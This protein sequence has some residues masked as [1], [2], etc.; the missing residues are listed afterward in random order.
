M[1]FNRELSAVSLPTRERAAAK[2]KLRASKHSQPAAH[3]QPAAPGQPATAAPTVTRTRVRRA[4]PPTL[5]STRPRR[6][7]TELTFT[8][9]DGELIV[10]SVN[11]RDNEE[12]RTLSVPFLPG[13]EDL[14]RKDDE[15]SMTEPEDIPP[16]MMDLLGY[17]AM[18]G[19][20]AGDDMEDGDD[21]EGGDDD[22]DAEGEDDVGFNNADFAGD[23][24]MG[25][26]PAYSHIP[27]TGLLDNLGVTSNVSTTSNFGV[28]SNFSE[29]SNFSATSNSGTTSNFSAISNP[30]TTSN[31]S[32]TSN[33]FNTTSVEPNEGP[34]NYSQA[35]G[36]MDFI[37]GIDQEE[38]Q[39]LFGGLGQFSLND[40]TLGDVFLTSTNTLAINF[41]NFSAVLPDTAPSM[42]DHS[43]TIAQLAAEPN[44]DLTD[45][46]M[47]FSPALPTRSETPDLLGHAGAPSVS[48]QS[49][50]CDRTP[51]LQQTLPSPYRVTRPLPPASPSLL[52]H[53]TISRA[54]TPCPPNQPRPLATTRGE[55]PILSRTGTPR[56]SRHSPLRAPTRGSTQ[57]LVSAIR[58]NSHLLALQSGA[59]S[60]A[61]STSNPISPY[62]SA[63][64]VLN[65]PALSAPTPLRRTTSLPDLTSDHTQPLIEQD[66][67]PSAETPAQD[68]EPST[69]ANNFSSAIGQPV[70]AVQ[71]I[72]R[73]ILD[74]YQLTSRIRRDR[75]IPADTPLL[76]NGL[77]RMGSLT[78]E[79]KKFIM[80]IE[81]FLLYRMVSTQAWLDDPVEALD[82]AME[83]GEGLMRKSKEDIIMTAGFRELVLSKFSNLRSDAL[84]NV[85]QTVSRI[86]DVVS[87]DKQKT[88][89]LMGNDLFIYRDHNKIRAEMFRADVILEV[90]LDVF[91]RSGK[92]LGLVFILELCALD[93][94]SERASLSSYGKL[95][96]Q[97]ATRGVPVA[98]ISF[99]ATM[100]YF[101]L[102]K[103]NRNVKK[104]RF[105][106]Q[107]Y[108]QHWQ[109]Y[110]RNLVTLPHLGTLRDDLLDRI[111]QVL[112]CIYFSFPDTNVNT[113]CRQEHLR[114]WPAD[115]LDDEATGLQL[116]W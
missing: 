73:N 88:E 13:Q 53:R 33:D 111:K 17:S 40:S 43:P 96:D 80:L 99:A 3:G 93:G 50:L 44:F 26:E 92:K 1:V 112:D 35:P 105:D 108:K 51:G 60:P 45:T 110:M 102:D 31:F 7:R 54:G 8:N 48:L 58:S 9:K 107:G 21:M 39:A 63:S 14:Q 27:S 103:M 20:G 5:A 34:F 42:H 67:N 56:F 64:Q 10:N 100:I 101:V 87:G 6:S 78:E 68:S 30:G 47:D 29:T 46:P 32:T 24:G 52:A 77:P 90:L 98:A 91:F 66:L 114:H 82:K 49:S 16:D 61:T 11:R 12:P 28:T 94:P 25:T 113:M 69:S 74:H 59:S 65:I 72:K 19:D 18:D 23:A 106:D 38:L 57:A 86:L 97:T 37:S 2:A 79:E 116:A 75:H 71:D 89:M 41:Q 36:S 55:S 95:R 109:R 84:R 85:Y 62:R 104:L 4:V 115:E 81:H 15:G 83:Y 76:A 22:D 70:P